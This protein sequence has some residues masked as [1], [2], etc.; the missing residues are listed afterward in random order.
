M[1]W[2]YVNFSSSFIVTEWREKFDNFDRNKD[3][4][5]SAFEL[6]RLLQYVGFNPTKDELV[7]YMKQLDKNSLYQNFI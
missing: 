5:I 3:G 4:G 2:K 1:F 7:D 6:E